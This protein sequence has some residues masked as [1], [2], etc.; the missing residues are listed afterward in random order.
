M[1]STTKRKH[2]IKSAFMCL[3]VLALVC[4]STNAFA[5]DDSP[6]TVGGGGGNRTSSMSTGDSP[7]IV[8]G[9]GGHVATE[10]AIQLLVGVIPPLVGILSGL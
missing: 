3:A 2:S 8:G 9:G 7:I 10:L 5:G 4:I 1:M 6:I